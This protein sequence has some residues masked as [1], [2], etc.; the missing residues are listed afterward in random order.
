[1]E[2]LEWR[3]WSTRGSKLP[4]RRNTKM[5]PYSHQRIPPLYV[6]RSRISYRMRG[7]LEGS[8][9]HPEP[10]LGYASRSSGW[11]SRACCFPLRQAGE[12]LEKVLHAGEA[13]A[14]EGREAATP[15]RG[16][17]AAAGSVGGPAPHRGSKFG[18]PCGR[19]AAS[20]IHR[21]LGRYDARL[22]LGGAPVHVPC[23]VQQAGVAGCPRA[24]L[25]E[26]LWLGQAWF[27]SSP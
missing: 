25:W 21:L 7:V 10:W 18:L 9:A 26:S 8:R 3:R 11:P 13:S 16:Q 23:A 1:M 2:A 4:T 14:G 17:R 5:R 20:S 19:G 6:H 27:F 24:N 15:P 12:H 22:G